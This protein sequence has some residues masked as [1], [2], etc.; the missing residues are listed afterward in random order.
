MEEATRRWIAAMRDARYDDAW[1]IEQA[2]LAQRNPAT[3]DDPTLPY[4]RRWVWDGRSPDGRDVLVRCY[5]GLGDTIQFARYL[6]LLASRAR[7]VTVEAPER[8][9][10]L[11]R[12]IVDVPLRAFAP[13]RPAP[14]AEL[15]IEI[16][17]LAFALRAPPLA[18]RVP[19]LAHTPAAL[20]RGTIGLCWQ[21]GDWDRDRW[22]PEESL[23]PIARTYPCLSLI[24]ERTTLAVL[25]PDGC[26]FDLSTT[27][28]LIAGC[29]LVVTVDTMVAHLAGAM[30]R[31]VWLMLKA[32]PDWRWNP[33]AQGSGWYPSARLYSQQ[34]SGDWRA[35]VDR[36]VR[37]LP[38]FFHQHRAESD[39]GQPAQPLG[40]RLLG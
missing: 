31:P 5:Q 27:A 25:N 14:P 15:D 9:H 1:A 30:G 7:S 28:A 6:P 33:H 35:V 20:P 11:L 38:G 8:L 16:T 26:A 17:E 40:A 19:Y 13:A 21:A 22:V 37:D 23:A 34:R 24:P 32:E 3:R 2:V 4:H 39:H 29:A 10:V 12:A 18:V 36:I